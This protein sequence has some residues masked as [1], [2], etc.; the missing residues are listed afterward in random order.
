MDSPLLLGQLVWGLAAIAIAIGVLLQRRKT[1]KRLKT[2][3][4]NKD[5]W[6][7][8]TPKSDKA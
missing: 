2:G 5:Y 1:A 3:R 7:P 6:S 8:P 4:Q